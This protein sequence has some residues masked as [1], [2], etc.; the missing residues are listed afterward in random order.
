MLMMTGHQLDLPSFA[1]ILW[2]CPPNQ[3]FNYQTVQL[4]KSREAKEQK[5]LEYCPWLYK[6][7]YWFLSCVRLFN[8]K[9]SV[10][11]STV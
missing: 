6:N 4:S 8:S 2:A 11:L 10:L 9:A 7:A 1:L 3:I 5:S